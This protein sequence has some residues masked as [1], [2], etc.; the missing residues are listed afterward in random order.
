MVNSITTV[1]N[2]FP[3]FISQLQED[4]SSKQSK[5]DITKPVLGDR[6]EKSNPEIL[7][8]LIMQLGSASYIEREAASKKLCEI[9]ESLPIEELPSFKEKLQPYS[10]KGTKAPSL[11]VKARV[12]KIIDNLYGSAFK[13][14]AKKYKNDIF[15][16]PRNFSSDND[17][18]I[19]EQAERL[20]SILK[21]HKNSVIEDLKI[22]DELRMPYKKPLEETLAIVAKH[23]TD[24]TILD[25]LYELNSDT[26]NYSISQNENISIKILEKLLNRPDR[27]IRAEVAGH[28]NITPQ[29]LEK[30]SEDNDYYVRACVGFNK[31]TSSIILERLSKDDDP[32]VRMSVASNPNTPIATLERLQLEDDEQV[33]SGIARNPQTPKAKLLELARDERSNVREWAASNSNL[34]QEVLGKL[35]NDSDSDVRGKVALNKNV[36]KEILEKLSMDDTPEVRMEVAK[37][38]Q[39]SDEIFKTLL[40]DSS[41]DVRASLLDNKNLPKSIFQALNEDLSAK[42]KEKLVIYKIKNKIHM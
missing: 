35:S 30:L 16:N 27:F 25:S 39:I 13:I 15:F 10:R 3:I 36:P 5:I 28:N 23:T 9:A 37:N 11:E 42:V 6:F 12:D 22:F 40:G 20:F 32:N 41:E 34:P 8:K 4:G 29:T 21:D 38:P 18:S 14:L 33:I 24:S 26:V 31:N 17:H 1:F 2:L 7:V 19:Y